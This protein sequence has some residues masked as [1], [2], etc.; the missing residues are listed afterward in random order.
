MTHPTA[1]Q[2]SGETRPTDDDFD[3]MHHAIGR[4]NSLKDAYRNYY[5]T[6]LGGS[7]AKRFEALGLWDLASTIN[8]GRDGIFTV[9]MAGIAALESW[10]SARAQPEKR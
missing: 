4:A 8:D 5:C 6:P 2:M 1:R 7:I 10:L 3:D 9:N